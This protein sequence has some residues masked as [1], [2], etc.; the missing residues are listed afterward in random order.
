MT[1]LK[2]N[3]LVLIVRLSVLRRT[4]LI[5]ILYVG[6]FDVCFSQF[7][8]RTVKLQVV[9]VNSDCNDSDDDSF[10][11][12]IPSRSISDHHLRCGGG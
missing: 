6:V 8:L 7:S 2:L 10:F 9:Q 11:L 5:L 4:I 12:S 3:P 1:W